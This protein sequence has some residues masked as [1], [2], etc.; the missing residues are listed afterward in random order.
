M[1]CLLLLYSLG[2]DCGWLGW[3]CLRSPSRYVCANQQIW[4]TFKVWHER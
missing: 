4:Q 3:L 2:V 1:L